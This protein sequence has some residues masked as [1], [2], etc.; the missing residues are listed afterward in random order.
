MHS[1]QAFGN[2]ES[3]S[4]NAQG[5]VMVE[6]APTAAFVVIQAEL[7]LQILI[8]AF[9][10][11]A[12]LDRIRQCLARRACRQIGQDVS[13]RLDFSFGPF[14]QQPFFLAHAIALPSVHPHGGQSS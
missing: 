12:G 13:G 6:A 5:R 8:I 9:D 14:D 4:G 7:L 10:R 2:Q 3:M 1:A 11:P